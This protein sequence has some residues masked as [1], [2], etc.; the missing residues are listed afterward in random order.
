[1][2]PC[3]KQGTGL[4]QQ[5]CFKQRGWA[6]PLVM[7]AS[8]LMLWMLLPLWSQVIQATPVTVLQGR[9]QQ[10]EGAAQVALTRSLHDVV[11]PYDPPAFKRR[12]HPAMRWLA[13]MSHSPSQTMPALTVKPGLKGVM[14]PCDGQRLSAQ[15]WA[16]AYG[17]IRGCLQVLLM[18]HE[19]QPW[20]LTS[21]RL[22]DS[23][24]GLIRYWQRIAYTE[25][26]ASQPEALSSFARMRYH[27]Q[28][29]CT[30]VAVRCAGWP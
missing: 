26:P 2:V 30:S 18:M 15:Y 27:Y 8:L 6:M 19:A 25:N 1:M 13:P 10:L 24:T 12:Q 14:S 23:T 21:L 28:A 5:V 20:V 4:K 16:G 29:A 7:I 22:E 9:Y 3:V 17:A 11:H